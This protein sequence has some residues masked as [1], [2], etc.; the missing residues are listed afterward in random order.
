MFVYAVYEAAAYV[1]EGGATEPNLV[2]MHLAEESAIAH[3]QGLAQALAEK[4]GLSVIPGEAPLCWVVPGGLWARG[5]WYVHK[6]EV[7]P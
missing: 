5:I 2:S 4:E 3:A 6:Y 1:N 7:R